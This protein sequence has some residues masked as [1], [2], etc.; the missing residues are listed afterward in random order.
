MP[1]LTLRLSLLSFFLFVE[2]P[3]ILSIYYLYL[4]I[5]SAICLSFYVSIYLSNIYEWVYVHIV[6]LKGPESPGC[7]E[8]IVL[9]IFN[10]KSARYLVLSAGK[11]S[12]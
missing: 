7:P 4:V 5:Y 11:S 12:R 3:A 6:K 8:P 2:D 9:V 10:I 1:S